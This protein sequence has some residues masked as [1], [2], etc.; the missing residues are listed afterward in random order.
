M[1][2]FVGVKELKFREL[3]CNSYRY[4]NYVYINWIFDFKWKDIND[5]IFD[6]FI[7]V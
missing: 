5:Y 3:L 2:K 6:L 1:V 4:S 7:N